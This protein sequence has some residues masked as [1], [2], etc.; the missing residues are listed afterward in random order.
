MEVFVKYPL[1]TEQVTLL[2]R[3]I[4]DLE[5]VVQKVTGAVHLIHTYWYLLRAQ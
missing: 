4:T 1:L 3:G 5:R 2:L